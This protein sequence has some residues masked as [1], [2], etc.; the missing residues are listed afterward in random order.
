MQFVS[1]QVSMLPTEA[2]RPFLSIIIPALNEALRLPESLR[3][4]DA[5][6]QQQPYRAEV[7][8]VENGS[9]DDTVGVVRAFMQD[10]PYVRLFAGEPRGKGRAVRRGMLE[11]RGAYRFLCDADLSMP[12]EE[13]NNFLP[14]KL[15]GYDVIIGSREAKG[16]RRYNEPWHRHFMGRINNL[17]IKLFAVRGFE[18]TQCGFKAFTARAAQDLFSVSVINGIGFDVEILFLAQKRG[19]RIAEV[20]INWYF[21]PDSRMRLVKDSLGIL[22]EIFAIRRNWRN[23]LYAKRS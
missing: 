14:P 8:V 23:G 10:H 5:F 17:I 1:E 19:Y 18:D 16:A 9:T 15:E 20:P 3:K 12:I 2:E 7:I 6:L 13:V 11:A 4:I 21:D 22:R